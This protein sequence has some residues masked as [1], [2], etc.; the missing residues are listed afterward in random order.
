MDHRTVQIY[1]VRVIRDQHHR[2]PSAFS[3]SCF[4]DS[5]RS[6]GKGQG[7]LSRAIRLPVSVELLSKALLLHRISVICSQMLHVYDKNVHHVRRNESWQ[8]LS[9]CEAWLLRSQYTKGDPLCAQTVMLCF[10]LIQNSLL[11]T[12]PILCS[13]RIP[14]F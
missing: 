3:I 6:P 2:L 14:S 12:L 11:R 5:G 4:M 7:L 10:E 8:P 13:Y 1:C 9:L